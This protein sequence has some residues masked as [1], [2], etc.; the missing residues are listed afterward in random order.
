MI[1]FFTK[2]EEQAIITEIQRAEN[3]TT[4]EIRV[5]IEKNPKQDILS[6]AKRVFKMLKMEQ[7]KDRSGVLIIL[8]PQIRKFAILGDKGIDE[9]LGMTFWVTERDRIQE[10]FRNEEY[11][12]G[13]CLAIEKVGMELKKHFPADEIN[14]NELPDDI[15]YS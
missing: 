2:E 1:N 12:K 4:G 6:E 13:V 10:Y 15:S 14:D 9:K 7:T 3:A 5:H 8:A 11:C